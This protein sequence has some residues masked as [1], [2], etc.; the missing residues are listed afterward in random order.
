MSDIIRLYG[1][2]VLREPTA[3]V[4]EFGQS[5]RD[6]IEQLAQTMYDDNGVGLAAPQ[7]GVSDKVVVIDTSFGEREGELL[8]LINPEIIETGGECS[9]EEGC[10]SVPGIYEEVKRPSYIRIRYQDL[11][12][13]DREL[14]AEE[15]LARVVQH[16]ADHLNGVLFID[17]L[18]SVKRQLL[19]KSLK[20]IMEKGSIG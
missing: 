18:S 12:G 3:T 15:Y 19:A 20:S 14:E 5:L 7:V 13:V 9:F 2:P 1:D 6:F 4:A 10:L 17:R 11:D 16:E 8:T